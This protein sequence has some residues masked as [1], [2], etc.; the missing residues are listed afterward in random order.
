MGLLIGFLART[1]PAWQPEA[2]LFIAVG[3]LGGFTTFSSFSLDTIALIERGDLVQA[4][5]YVL[6]SVAISL[7]GLYLG[8]LMMRG[9]VA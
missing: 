3:V 6:L 2:R 5:L 1:T 7:L 9:S 8:L 4:V